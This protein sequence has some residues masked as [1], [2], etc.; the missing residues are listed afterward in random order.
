MENINYA[1]VSA[2]ENGTILALKGKVNSENSHS[3]EGGMLT[4]RAAH[5]AGSLSIDASVLESIS[6]SGL[7]VLMRLRQ[8]EG[9]LRIFNVSEDVYKAFKN[10]GLI[11][12]I[13]VEKAAS[14]A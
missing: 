5:P 13:E 11:G 9:S 10:T 8:N 1:L 3:V 4:L 14:A 7:N 12:L 2:D 6:S